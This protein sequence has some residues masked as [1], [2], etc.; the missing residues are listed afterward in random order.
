M[1]TEFGKCH[2]EG[3]WYVKNK[4]LDPKS[5]SRARRTREWVYGRVLRPLNACHAQIIR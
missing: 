4:F 2:L 3:P 5:Q 1:V